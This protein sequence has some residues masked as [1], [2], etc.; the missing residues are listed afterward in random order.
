VS[1]AFAANLVHFVRYLRARGLTVVP[2]TAQDLARAGTMVG[3]ERRSDVYAAFRAV[4]VSRPGEVPIFDEA[5]A[6]FFEAGDSTT[7]D[8]EA[9]P[10]DPS[11]VRETLPV[12]IAAVAEEAGTDRADVVETVGASGLERLA[13]RDFGELTPEE[14]EI[15]RR[16]ISRMIWRPAAARSRRWGPAP[17]G[18]RPDLRRTFRRLAGPEGDLMPLAYASR[19]E[20]RRPLVVLADIS[21]SMERYSELFLH[22]VHAAQGRLGRVEAFVF[23]TRL[24]RITREMRYREPRLALARVAAS[25]ED[26]SGGTRI[27]ETLA[28][29]N[30]EWSRRVTRGGAIALVI[31]DGWDTGDPTLLHDEMARLARSVHRV[32]WLSP[33]AGLEGFSPETRGLRAVMPFV[34]DFLAASNILDLADVVR[35]LESVPATRGTNPHRPRHRTARCAGP[36]TRVRRSA[37]PA[38][39][40]SRLVGSLS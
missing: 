24:T 23:G 27:G 25:V 1:E 11:T 10:E 15:V 22:F 31:S 19:R 39:P 6:R 8:D 37:R 18:P 12:A 40:A 14:Q 29:F 13:R 20:R 34:D 9:A 28:T 36:A 16:L 38:R 7:V 33:Y 21:G 26:W 3:F 32:V 35:L 4:V 5:F 17:R 30:R 2:Q